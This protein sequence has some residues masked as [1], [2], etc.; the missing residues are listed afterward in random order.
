MK[1]TINYLGTFGMVVIPIA[2]MILSAGIIFVTKIIVENI[3]LY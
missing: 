3:N 2:V 1:N